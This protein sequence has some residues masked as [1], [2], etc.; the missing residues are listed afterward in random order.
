MSGEIIEFRSH[1][2]LRRARLSSQPLIHPGPT[3][4]AT[5]QQQITRILDLVQELEETSS[6]ED[7]RLPLLVELPK[8]CATF[9]ASAGTEEDI[10]DIHPQPDVDHEIL[11][12]IYGDLKCG[13][14]AVR[15]N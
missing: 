15:R 1:H 4:G 9:L 13:V 5:L 3:Q 14:E 6:A 12:R 2:E 10:G 11:E 7:L 8:I